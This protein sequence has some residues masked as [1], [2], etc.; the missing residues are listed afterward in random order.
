MTS[1]EPPNPWFSTI[2]FNESFFASNTQ[3][4][5][6]AYANANYLKRVG[7]AVS[8]ASSTTFSG[9][10]VGGKSFTSLSSGATIFHLDNLPGNDASL[11]IRNQNPNHNLFYRQFGTTNSHIFT[12]NGSATTNL[13]LSNALN[14]SNLP[15]SVIGDVSLTGNI[16]D[17]SALNIS[18]TTGTIQLQANS[19]TASFGLQ[20]ETDGTSTFHSVIRS[21]GGTARGI[22]IENRSANSGGLGLKNLNTASNIVYQQSGTTNSHIFSTN[23]TATTNL[24]LSN[25]MNT[26]GIPFTFSRQTLST[27]GTDISGTVALSPPL[28]NLYFITATGA[29]TISLPTVGATYIGTRLTFRRVVAGGIIT[30]NV[31]GGAS[32]IFPTGQ[33]TAGTPSPIP[34][35]ALSATT[36]SAEFLCNGSFWLQL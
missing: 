23:G 21:I 11:V 34:A 8:V 31:T 24:T 1:A 35:T 22:N 27:P 28:N 3:N 9:G 18:S 10:E 20:I 36:V 16:I 25:T 33:P 7:I 13:T 30:I 17:T 15:L 4:I 29:I 6:L 2:N 32:T 12:T 14:T 26:S 19:G 5:T